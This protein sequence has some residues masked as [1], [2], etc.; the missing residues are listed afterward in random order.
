MNPRDI[1]IKP[2]I[3]EKTMKLNSENNTYTFEVLKSSNKVQVKLAVEEIF[4]V[5]VL[6]VSTVNTKS[7]DKR[8][9]KYLGKTKAIKKA[10]VKLAEG[11]TIDLGI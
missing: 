6:S 10:Y 2:L 9:G 5:K 8:V 11:S 3:T 4:K 1:I 7:K